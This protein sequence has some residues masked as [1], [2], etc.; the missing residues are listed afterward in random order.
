[1]IEHQTSVYRGKPDG[2]NRHK[3]AGEHSTVRTV[4]SGEMQTD[5]NQSAMLNIP[6]DYSLEKARLEGAQEALLNI[7]DDFDQEKIR[8]QDM[9]RALLNV[10][11]DFD[12]E[13]IKIGQANEMLEAR[14]LELNLLN[15]E[16][17]KARD[18]LELEVAKRVVELQRSN[19]DLQRF[20]Y[21][22]SH[23]LQEPLRTI[24]S[25]MQLLD[26][27][28]KAQLDENA[29]KYINAAV[30][31]ANR[32][33][34]MIT[35]LLEYS[36][37]ETR[38]DPFEAVNCEILLSRVV[39]DLKKSIDENR[40]QITYGAMPTVLGDRNQLYRV[41]QNLILN[42]IKYRSDAPPRLHISAEIKGSD[43][44]FSVRDNGIGIDPQYK[45][46]I[47][48]I[49]QRLQGR[50]V[51]GI[52]LGLSIVQKIIERHGGHIWVESEPGKGATFY[53]SIPNKGG[54]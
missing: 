11:E 41:F 6:E 30:Q 2:E 31:G 46:R 10:L 21:I 23:D 33:Q 43:Y 36:R 53:F 29:A 54:A 5:Y 13:K 24:S 7:L 35:G 50:E 39:G 14:S 47:F 18:T 3:K 1:M 38:G 16:L 34:Q 20:A 22:A 42:A 15:E 25:Y 27:R 17:Q 49:F 19:S 26:R 37:V 32:L 4:D 8:L 28:Y 40:A 9:Q 45:E 44:V 48:I 52:G 12:I 51:P